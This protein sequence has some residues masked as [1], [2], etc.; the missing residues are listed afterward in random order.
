ML[1]EGSYGTWGWKIIVLGLNGDV[2][3]R[4]C[5]RVLTNKVC[6]NKNPLISSVTFSSEQPMLL[7]T[8]QMEGKNFDKKVLYW[9]HAFS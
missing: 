8:L 9:R 7:K 6:F 2:N 4:K 1:F 3:S 5:V